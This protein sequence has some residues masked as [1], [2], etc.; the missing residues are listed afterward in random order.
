MRAVKHRCVDSGSA[1]RLDRK[2]VMMHINGARA[3][4]K[5]SIAAQ[6]RL[7]VIESSS[8]QHFSSEKSYS[9]SANGRKRKSMECY[10]PKKTEWIRTRSFI[11]HQ[12]SPPILPRTPKHRLDNLHPPRKVHRHDTGQSILGHVFSEFRRLRL[13]VTFQRRVV[14]KEVPAV[15]PVPFP[16]VCVKVFYPA[17]GGAKGK[18]AEGLGGS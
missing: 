17:A 8:S 9:I 5:K 11:R 3:S 18:A 4:K 10:I 14:L 15:L 12:W 16:K 2:V 1:P 13:A 7:R 6:T